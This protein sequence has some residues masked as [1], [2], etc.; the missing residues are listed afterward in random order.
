MKPSDIELR[1]ALIEVDKVPEEQDNGD[2]PRAAILQPPVIK[3]KKKRKKEED[4]NI[5][6][7]M[8]GRMSRATE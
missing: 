2:F 6:P 4:P 8:Y 1:A 3:K 5:I 7:G